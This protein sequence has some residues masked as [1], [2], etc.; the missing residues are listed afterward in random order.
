MKHLPRS[1]RPLGLIGKNSRKFVCKNLFKECGTDINVEKGA[2]FGSGKHIIL[3]DRSGIGVDCILSGEINIG[4]DVMMGPR[5][6]LL[7]RN[8]SYSKLDVPMNIQG[9]NR[10]KPIT[11]DNDVWIGFG[12]IILGG[13]KVGK[14]SIVAAGAI[15]TKNV[16]PYTIVG[17]N[18]AC[19][20]GS[21]K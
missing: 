19:K 12:A 2:D 1:S 9:Y 10:M 17:G 8:H 18:P 21:R 16:P 13:V 20:I 3:G 7:A 15:V 14:G 11:I 6:A 4:N 5:C